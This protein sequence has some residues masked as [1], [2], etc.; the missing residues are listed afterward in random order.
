M[1]EETIFTAAL[2]QTPIERSAFL[3]EAC[4]EDN[5]LRQRIER[6]LNLHQ[7]AGDF[8]ERPAAAEVG[9]S[10]DDPELERLG[11][12]IGV[13]KLLQQIGEGGM[14]VVYM[15]EQVEPVVRRVAIKVMK[16]GA[17]SRQIIARF[18]IERRRWRSW[19]TPI[20]QRCLTR[21]RF[22]VRAVPTS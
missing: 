10:V 2:D 8:L 21:E 9:F 20:S 1:R 7:V 15:A 4:G 6:L 16:P 5:S 22:L 11:A 18:E 13:Y 3:D 14:G 17:G 19:T 12:Q